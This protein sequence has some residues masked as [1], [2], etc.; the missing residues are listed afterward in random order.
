MGRAM[1][2][3]RIPRR[4]RQNYEDMGLQGQ[5]LQFANCPA[6]IIEVASKYHLIW[7]NSVLSM[8]V[9]VE[10]LQRQ[11]GCPLGTL[12]VAGTPLQEVYDAVYPR[13]T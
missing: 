2:V 1:G 7:N 11:Y 10:R 9:L 8:T 4:P 12:T 5:R 6:E 3:Q 13:A